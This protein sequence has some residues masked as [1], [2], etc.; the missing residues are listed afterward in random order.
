MGTLGFAYPAALG[1]KVARPDAP[2][3]TVVG[4]GGFLFAS[5][6]LATA[7]QHGINTVTV[8][9]DDS[10][11][12]NSN[13]DQRERYRGRELGTVLR[14]PD[15]VRLAEAFGAQGTRVDDIERLPEVLREAC[16]RDGSTVIAVP[17]DRLPSPF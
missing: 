16:G 2:V 6:E 13:R 7:V 15:W 3:V 5:N 8:V 12:G 4:D 1:A 10:A 17:M 9:F 11:Y 14:N